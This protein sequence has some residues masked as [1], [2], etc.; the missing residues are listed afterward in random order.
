LLGRE[1][2]LDAASDAGRPSDKAALLKL[3]DQPMDLTWGD[4]QQI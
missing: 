2:D 1:Q 3:E 4:R